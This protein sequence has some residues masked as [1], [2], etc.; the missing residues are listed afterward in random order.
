MGISL[1]IG[2]IAAKFAL[3]YGP[4]SA[5][6]VPSMANSWGAVLT[7]FVF[8]YTACFGASGFFVWIRALSFSTS[9]LIKFYPLAWL[10]VPWLYPV[11]LDFH[12]P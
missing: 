10:T 9:V 6:P 1:L 2:G 5:M 11:R 12:W 3:K 8:A 4:L 7:T